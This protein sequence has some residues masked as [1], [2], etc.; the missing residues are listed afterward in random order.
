[1]V[2]LFLHFVGVVRGHD[3]AVI[4]S[5]EKGTQGMRLRNGLQRLVCGVAL[6]GAVYAFQRPFREFGGMEYDI[7]T[8]PM[9]RTGRRRP[10]GPSHGWCFLPVRL[11]GFPAGHA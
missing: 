9:P 7:G 4:C 3:P 5:K 6:I 8:I 1:M 10:S 11:T 2:L